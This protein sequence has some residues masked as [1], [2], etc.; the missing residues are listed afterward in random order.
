MSI[1]STCHYEAL[2][3]GTPTVIL[4]F[5]DLEAMLP[6]INLG[7]GIICEKPVD[8]FNMITNH[9]YQPVNDQIS[10]RFFRPN[11]IEN[12]LDFVSS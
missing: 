12:I 9:E 10:E 5:V 4:P 7:Y 8:L 6:L 11:A 3:L 2:A 1:A